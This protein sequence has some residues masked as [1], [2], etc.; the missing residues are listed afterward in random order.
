MFTGP[1]DVCRI[2][3]ILYPGNSS[4]IGKVPF[5]GI[6]HRLFV[7]IHSLYGQQTVLFLKDCMRVDE[8]LGFDFVLRTFG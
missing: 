1:A 4:Y 2:R 7:E 6:R 8:G 5:P 3:I